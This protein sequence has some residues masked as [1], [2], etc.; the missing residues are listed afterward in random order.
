MCFMRHRPVPL[1]VDSEALWATRPGGPRCGRNNCGLFRILPELQPKEQAGKLL[2]RVVRYSTPVYEV[3]PEG[4]GAEGSIAGSQIA[5]ELGSKQEAKK[6]LL[7]RCDASICGL[8]PMFQAVAVAS[9]RIRFR[10]RWEGPGYRPRI[11]KRYHRRDSE[12]PGERCDRVTH[13][14][15]SRFTGNLGQADSGVLAHGGSCFLG[16]VREEADETRYPSSLDDL[17]EAE[18]TTMAGCISYSHDGMYA[19]DRTSRVSVPSPPVQ[20]CA[21]SGLG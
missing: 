11:A 6:I 16:T 8:W 13:S 14:F 3:I 12:P 20:T 4:R 2:P 5:P 21:L 9:Y 18:R 17:V 7:N 15:M 10:S 19:T 1:L